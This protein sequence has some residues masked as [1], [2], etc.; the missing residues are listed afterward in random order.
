MKK[1]MMMAMMLVASAAAFAGDS[2]ALKAILKAKTYA[3][4]EALV[5]SSVG[6]LAND[7]E[8]AKAYNKLVDLAFEKFKKED[9]TRITNQAL[10]KNDP[11]DTEGMIKAGIDAL[12]AALECDKYDVLPDAK[13]KVKPAF[14]KKNQDRLQT[15]RA[16]LLNAGFGYANDNKNKEV[17]DCLNPYLLTADAPLFKDLETVKNDPNKGAAAFY[18]GRAALQMDMNA[19]AAEIFKIGV[20]DT[21]KQVHDLCF[22]MLIYTLGKTRVTREDSLKYLNDMKELYIQYPES[23][24]VYASLSDALNQNGQESEVLK[25][26][27]EHLAKYPN[28]A[29]P[30]VYKAFIAQGQKKFADAIAEWNLV[31]ESTVNYVQFVFYRA[32][33]KYSLAAEFNEANADIRTG[34]LSPENDKKYRGMLEDAQKDFEKAQELDPD[35]LTVKWGYLLKNV[36]HALGQDE[37]ADAI[38]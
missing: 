38:L 36:Y 5:K 13:G 29:L 7:Q 25:L 31:P 4:A 9:D 6:S 33:C 8:K 26:A 34:N 32:V 16:S 23:E 30:H 1:L 3:E 21:A 10:Q 24:Q 11:I 35:Q 14:Q 22:D 20:Q 12:N 2:D 28:S 27:D 37:K 18:A 17:Y 19:R 15:V